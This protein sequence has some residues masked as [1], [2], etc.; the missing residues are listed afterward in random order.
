MCIRDRLN[1]RRGATPFFRF[2][3]DTKDSDLV[4]LFGENSAA[5]LGL[6]LAL[7]AV[8]LSYV[9]HDPRWDALGSL[10]IGIVL[11]GVAI[12]LAV[13]IKSLL[14]GEAADPKI[15]SAARD[16]AQELEQFDEVLSVITVQQGPG[17]VLFA[18]KVRLSNDM[19]SDQVVDA[20]NAFEVA[21]RKRCP[22]VKWS[23]V[24]PDVEA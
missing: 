14:V 11:I 2:L 23:F 8:G 9:T 22:E 16:V 19:T 17:E 15:A 20:I 7:A 21:L 5:S 1:R 10:A 3:R 4:V 12:F 6:T 13:E 18:A 24:E